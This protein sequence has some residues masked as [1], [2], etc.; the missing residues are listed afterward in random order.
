[1]SV[2]ISTDPAFAQVT[3]RNAATGTIV[4]PTGDGTY[5]LL[6]GGTYNV[7]CTAAGYDSKTTTFTVPSGGSSYEYKIELQQTT[8]VVPP[9]E[10]D[11]DEIWVPPTYVVD[12]GGSDDDTI[13]I[14]ACAAAAVAAA[15]VAC[16]IIIEYRKR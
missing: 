4:S 11:D 10:Q 14:V 8:V 7:I 5:S 16:L 15:I 1:M 12:D 6:A 3:V 13:S 2:T 9:F